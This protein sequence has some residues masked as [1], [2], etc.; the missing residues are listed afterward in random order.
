MAGG[1]PVDDAVDGM[2]HR[3]HL[4]GDVE[5][6][7][8]PMAVAAAVRRAQLWLRNVTAGELAEVFD[9]F[10]QATM[11]WTRLTYELAHGLFWRDAD[12]RPFADPHCWAPFVS[13][14]C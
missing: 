1:Q 2:V 12:E 6:G 9:G 10:R 8:G 14:G 3:Y 13:Y 11:G 7:E 4:Q 5:V